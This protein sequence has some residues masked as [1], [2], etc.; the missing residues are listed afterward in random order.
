MTIVHLR[1][2]YTTSTHKYT[3]IYEPVSSGHTTRRERC[4]DDDDDKN[5]E[6]NDD[7]DDYIGDGDSNKSM[8]STCK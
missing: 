8:V 6:D 3:H 7:G 2:G 4:H 1:S 5:E